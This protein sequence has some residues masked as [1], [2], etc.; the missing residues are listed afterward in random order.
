MVLVQNDRSVNA[1]YLEVIHNM[2]R[3]KLA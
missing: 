3:P 1:S 2:S